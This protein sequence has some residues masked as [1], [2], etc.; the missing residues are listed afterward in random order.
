MNNQKIIVTGGSGFIGSNYIRNTIK[1]KNITILNLDKLSYAGN[2][3][4]TNDFKDLVNYQFVEGDI[5]DRDTL[6]RIFKEFK[7]D[8]LINFAAESHVDR[9]ID[10]SNEF[11]NT[12][13][14][15][16]Y[17]LL[18]VVRLYLKKKI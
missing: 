3:V 6:T 12:N 1:K 18:E 14:N 16:T 7:P 13:I 17:N 10:F 4:S 5:Q 2:I 8:V 9:S 15:G 11:I